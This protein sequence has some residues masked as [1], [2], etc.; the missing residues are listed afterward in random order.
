MQITTETFVVSEDG[1]SWKCG[2]L[3]FKDLGKIEGGVT[4]RYEVNSNGDI[5]GYVL[6]RSGWR[7]Y[8]YQ[9][10]ADTVYDFSC[11]TTI[12]EFVRLCT[13]ERK[14][15]WGQQGRFADR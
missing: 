9:P 12:A 7:R 8:T 14:T 15:H 10:K 1:K 3:T 2:W 4:R 13:D 6:W 11:L 5:L